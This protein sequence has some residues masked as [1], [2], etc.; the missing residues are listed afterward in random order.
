MPNNKLKLSDIKKLIKN[1]SIFDE[2]ISIKKKNGLNIKRKES[3]KN[4]NIN[5]EINNNRNIIYNT[6]NK[7]INKI[8]N[9]NTKNREKSLLIIIFQKLR[10]SASFT[11][12]NISIN[13]LKNVYNSYNNH[14]SY[15]QK[16]KNYNKVINCKKNKA[17]FINIKFP[18]AKFI[19]STNS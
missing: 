7:R 5:I 8:N 16:N 17:K 14:H 9:S 1:N 19:N 18:K 4:I 3:K 2:K 13:S 12:N 11:K 10:I 6:I 15:F